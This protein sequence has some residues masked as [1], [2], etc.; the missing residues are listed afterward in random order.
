MTGLCESCGEP[1]QTD[2]F[3]HRCWTCKN[4]PRE[5]RYTDELRYLREMADHGIDAANIEQA[6]ATDKSLYLIG[7]CGTGKTRIAH[8]LA[9][10][11][12]DAGKRVRVLSSHTRPLADI[13]FGLSLFNQKEWKRDS[14]LRG[15]KKPD[16]LLIDDFGKAKTTESFWALA[17]D[18]I[19]ARA[20]N[21]RQTII[22]AN[23][24]ILD[25]AP[26]HFKASLVR[27][28]EEFYRVIKF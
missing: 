2:G 26:E 14:V 9:K 27:R 13:S 1:F 17:H 11:C 19:D 25:T 3:I 6:L 12:H 4:I 7:S 5:Y 22:T 28:I 16:L 18:I 8:V 15:L 21:G 23:N 24:H 10:R 20:S